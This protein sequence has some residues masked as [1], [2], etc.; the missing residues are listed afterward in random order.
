MGLLEQ[1]SNIAYALRNNKVDVTDT[2]EII[3]LYETLLGCIGY[4]QAIAENE[5]I[6]FIKSKEYSVVL[7]EF[8]R[9]EYMLKK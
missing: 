9:K 3:D 4:L 8:Y 1:A 6:S 7:P 5:D 2:C